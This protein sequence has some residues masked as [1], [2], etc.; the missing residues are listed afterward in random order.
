MAD[1]LRSV[2]GLNVIQI[3][4]ARHQPHGAAGDLDARHLAARARSTAARSTSTSSGSCSGTSCRLRPRARSSR[5]RSCA[6]R[7]RSSGAPTR[8]TGVV[9]IITK[10]PRENEGFGARAGR[11]GSSTATAAR[12]RTDG[13]G[14]QYNG[15]FSLRARAQRHLVVPADR[16]L[17][18]LRP[19][20][21][22]RGQRP[23]RLPPARRVNAVPVPA[24]TGASSR[25]RRW[26]ADRR[27]GLSRRRA[28]SPGAF[29]NE[30]TSQPKFDLRVDQDLKNGGR[31]LYEGGY[32]GTEGIVHTGHRP[33]RPPERLVHGLRPGRLHQGRAAQ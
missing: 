6:G 12:A 9:N 33:V 25:R 8:V 24:P 31:I 4:G 21:R 19:V 30:G 32:D 7:P 5:S 3:V 14:Y 27:R 2:P 20:S 15:G 17:L 13:D 10:T 11:R 22:A 1:T 26:R 28:V 18:Q 29:E 16:R 23:A